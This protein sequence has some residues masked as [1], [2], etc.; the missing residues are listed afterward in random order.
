MGHPRLA[1]VLT[2]LA[3]AGCAPAARA[4]VPGEPAAADRLRAAEEQVHG[5]VNAYRAHQ[6][7][8]RL[9]HHPHLAEVARLHS[10]A[11]AAGEAPFGHDGLDERLQVVGRRVPVLRFGENLY[12]EQPASALSA[13]RAVTGWLE[14]PVHRGAIEEP[15]YELTGIGAAMDGSGRIYYTQLFARRLRPRYRASYPLPQRCPWHA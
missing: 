13:W 15:C 7:L 5:L 1:A 2:A 14:S 3:L 12:A 8:R 11:M 4:P 9:A 10:A 6:G